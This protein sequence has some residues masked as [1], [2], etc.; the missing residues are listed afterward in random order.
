M[1]GKSKLG[2]G[3]AVALMALCLAGGCGSAASR[4]Q[5]MS[6]QGSPKYVFLFIGDGM[7]IVQAHVAEVY[8]HAVKNVGAADPKSGIEKL[9][10]SSFPVMGLMTT[11]SANQQ[12]TDSAAAGTAIATGR[13]TANE[14]DSMDPAGKLC[15]ASV[16]DAARARGMKV[17][18]VSSTSITDATPAVFYAHQSSRGQQYEI[19]LQLAASPFEYF[20]G[21]KVGEAEGLQGN[22]LE[23]AARNGLKV[24]TTREALA[25][26]RPGQRV[27]FQDRMPCEMDRPAHGVTLAE[28]TAKGIELLDNPDGF[29]MMV[30]GAKID[31][32]GH[33]NDARTLIG[34]TLALDAAIDEALRFYREHPLETLIVVTADH[35][36]GG[37]TLNTDGRKSPLG[38]ASLAAQKRSWPAFSSEVF[39]PFKQKQAWTS[40]ADNIPDDLK[41]S[42]RDSFGLDWE[43]LGDAQKDTLED[44]YDA[45]M[46]TRGKLDEKGRRP[47]LPGY[48]R[49]EPLPVT[50]SRVVGD[51]AGIGWTTTSHTCVP[52]PVRALGAAAYHFDG[53]YDNT[54]I[55]KKLAGILRVALPDPSPVAVEK[56]PA[57]E[58]K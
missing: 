36:T 52:V 57:A 33:N 38:I 3:L 45:S 32:A 15:Y 13:K 18:I 54:D 34:E 26:C 4:K 35:E 51:R 25:E 6:Q 37:M 19:G 1:F 23:L 5:A 48:G 28:L 47:S 8:R 31:G 43:E 39:T 7:G 58:A 21:G 44:A 27:L 42:I 11:Y 2:F 46:A 9:S 29:F 24:V 41:L 50:V 49:Y 16:A 12:T 30:E 55:A 10:M 14:T 53:F 40:T 20:A 56:Q 17:G 22:V